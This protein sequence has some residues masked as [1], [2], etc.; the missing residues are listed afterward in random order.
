MSLHRWCWAIIVSPTHDGSDT[1]QKKFVKIYTVD[2]GAKASYDVHPMKLDPTYHI[3]PLF[4]RAAPIDCRRAYRMRFLKKV[5]HESKP[6]TVV[7]QLVL[8]AVRFSS[9][10]SGFQIRC[11]VFSLKPME[12]GSSIM[13]E[14]DTVPADT[15]LSTLQ[16]SL[17]PMF[18]HCNCYRVLL[19]E[20]R[21][22]RTL[23]RVLMN[24]FARVELKVV[25]LPCLLFL[26]VKQESSDMA[27]S[28]EEVFRR[29]VF[30][31]VGLNVTFV[32]WGILQVGHC[33]PSYC[34]CLFPTPLL[35]SRPCGLCRAYMP[36]IH[37]RGG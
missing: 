32:L 1:Q 8:P 4:G 34:I 9:D 24:I 29:L 22:L 10:V 6:H 14:S 23:L 37:L 36:N 20:N 18:T 27:M 12:K 16:L 21:I 30:L 28:R 7:P 25:D 2:A 26:F 31:G 17:L 11:V 13:E 5:E 15:N 35:L 19:Y 33:R 3:F